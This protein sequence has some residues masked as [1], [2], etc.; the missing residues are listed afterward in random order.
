MISRSFNTVSQISEGMRF[1]S[2]LGLSVLFTLVM[3]TGAYSQCEPTTDC[4][5]NGVLDSC[6]LSMG[7]SDDCDSNGIPDEC[8]IALGT[9]LDCNLN[10]IPDSCEPPSPQTLMPTGG[11]SSAAS[12][13][14]SGDFAV[15]GSPADSSIAPNAGAAHIFR[16][17]GTVWVEE[18][19]ELTASDAADSDLFGSS[20]SIDGDLIAVGAPGADIGAVTDAGAIYVFRRVAG[21][22]TQESKLTRSAPVAEDELGSSVS[23]NG[24]RILAG[25]PMTG[26]VGADTGLG[27]IFFHDGSSW[28]I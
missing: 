19:S 5:S 21:V 20:V 7:T 3:M 2:S 22:W 24:S 18:G 27:L 13:S 12:V 9:Q 1:V 11:F 26:A 14:I 28:A 6:D 25:A 16:R 10:G 15:V 4:N 8:D 17:V 23:A